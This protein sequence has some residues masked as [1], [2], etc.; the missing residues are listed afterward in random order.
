MFL[1]HRYNIVFI[2]VIVTSSA[3]STAGAVSMQAY[4][5][6]ATTAAT[7]TMFHE[8]LR[9]LRDAEDAATTDFVRDTLH[10]AH[11]RALNDAAVAATHALFNEELRALH[12]ADV[13]TTNDFVRDALK[14]RIK[15]ILTVVQEEMQVLQ[16][17]QVEA[18]HELLRRQVRATMTIT[19]GL[20]HNAA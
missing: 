12:D 8:K 6:A 13:V 15:A 19:T 11:R 17:E 1:N 18:S 14:M 9:V 4:H 3:E 5:E 16:E 20:L 2:V 7:R 10:V